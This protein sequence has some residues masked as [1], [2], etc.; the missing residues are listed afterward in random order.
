MVLDERAAHVEDDKA[1]V[2]TRLRRQARR[3]QRC[4]GSDRKRAAGYQATLAIQ[5]LTIPIAARS[6]RIKVG[7]IVSAKP[8]NRDFAL[9]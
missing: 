3:K 5:A 6:T 2:T 9:P 1:Q 4:G 8:G 7:K